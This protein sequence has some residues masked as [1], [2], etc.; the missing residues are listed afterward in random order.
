MLAPMNEPLA[1][2]S[3]V[4]EA[5]IFGIC[6]GLGLLALPLLAFL[7]GSLILGPYA[8]GSAGQI[9]ENEFRGLASGALSAWII[10]LGPYV[11]VQLIRAIWNCERL[12]MWLWPA[13]ATLDSKE[14]GTRPG[15]S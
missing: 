7:A 10:A 11:M 9:I 5:V 13:R 12:R 14:H 6:L 3:P 15:E 2:V 1:P 8:G 4:R